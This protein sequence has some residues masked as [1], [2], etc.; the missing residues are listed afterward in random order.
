MP[1]NVPEVLVEQAFESA[2]EIC[3]RC[4]QP[5]D[6]ILRDNMIQDPLNV[7]CAPLEDCHLLLQL[8]RLS[9]KF[10]EVSFA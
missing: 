4:S 8:P 7:L 2:K 1:V 3:S 6:F 10:L 9:Q 5:F